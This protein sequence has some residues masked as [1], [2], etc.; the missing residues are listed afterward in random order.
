MRQKTNWGWSWHQ[1]EALTCMCTWD[2][3]HSHPHICENMP[4]YLCTYHIHT[5]KNEK[6]KKKTNSK[7][8]RGFKRW[9]CSSADSI[10][11]TLRLVPVLHKP[12]VAVHTCNPNTS[13]SEVQAH[14][15]LHREFEA[16]KI[17]N[18]CWLNC[19][20]LWCL[21]GEGPGAFSVLFTDQLAPRTFPRSCPAMH[22]LL[23]GF[24]WVSTIVTLWAQS[25]TSFLFCKLFTPSTLPCAK[26]E[27]C[28]GNCLL[29]FIL[30]LGTKALGTDASVVRVRVWEQWIH[31]AFWTPNTSSKLFLSLSH[32][33]F[34]SQK[35]WEA[36][37]VSQ[38]SSLLED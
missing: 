11:E 30:F 29:H 12:S 4:A 27:N 8:R 36:H 16:Q 32:F 15:Q 5:W 14:P 20:A 3:T 23:L 31:W 28:L 35:L 33:P 26:L 38:P 25:F 9:G 7:F 13:G 34:D 18:A 21:R 1:F 6:V 10:Y 37:C 19:S 17:L 2:H 24:L 22:D